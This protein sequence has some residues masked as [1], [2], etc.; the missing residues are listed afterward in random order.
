MFVSILASISMMATLHAGD[1][2]TLTQTLTLTLTQP[3]MATGT[4]LLAPATTVTTP[5]AYADHMEVARRAMLNGEFDIARREFAAAAELERQAGRLPVEAVTGLA[6]ALYSQ[7]YNREA[8]LAMERLAKEAAARGDSNAEAVA[9]A[10]AI[11]LNSDA[12]QRI[13]ARRQAD[14]L[15]KIMKDSAITAETRD[16]VRIR[17][18]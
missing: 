13:T 5:R 3:P 2:P 4:T 7:S 11:W 8:A 10:D 18:G 16:L 14:R 15:R 1:A 12:G 17:V 6:H 9:L